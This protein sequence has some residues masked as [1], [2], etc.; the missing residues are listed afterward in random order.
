MAECQ[1]ALR[2]KPLPSAHLN[3]ALLLI[4]KGDVG[5]AR[6][7]LEA[8]LQIDANYGPALKAL[9]AITPQT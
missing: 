9:Q 6:R 2:L 3:I 8:A 1:E 4:K 7:H 5:E